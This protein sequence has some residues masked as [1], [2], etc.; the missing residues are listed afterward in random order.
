MLDEIKRNAKHI[1][2][3]LHIYTIHV[4]IAC[5]YT[6][7]QHVTYAK[8]STVL[9]CWFSYIR[10]VVVY[11]NTHTHRHRLSDALEYYIFVVVAFLVA[12]PVIVAAQF[13]R[14]EEQNR[15]RVDSSNSEVCFLFHLQRIHLT[16][17]FNLLLQLRFYIFILFDARS[18][19]PHDGSLDAKILLLNKRH[20]FQRLQHRCEILTTLI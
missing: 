1:F 10:C 9:L 4:Y 18:Q 7:I 12:F 5:I 2:S 14:C 3:L 11:K 8:I 20:C 15:G 6:Y 13:M 16:I 17:N 19:Y